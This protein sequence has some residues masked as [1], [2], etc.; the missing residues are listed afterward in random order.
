LTD[1]TQLGEAKEG[2]GR[3]ERLDPTQIVRHLLDTYE[4]EEVEIAE[5]RVKRLTR[6]VYAVEVLEH[7]Q[8]EPEAYFLSVSDEE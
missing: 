8:N 4:S 7:G 2:E 1:E 5:V 3:A 6:S